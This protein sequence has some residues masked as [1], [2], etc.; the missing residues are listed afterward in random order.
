MNIDLIHLLNLYFPHKAS[1]G[2]FSQFEFKNS[3]STCTSN[4]AFKI[5]YMSFA[6]S[7][8]TFIEFSLPSYMSFQQ[9]WNSKLCIYWHKPQILHIHHP[10]IAWQVASYH[11]MNVSPTLLKFGHSSILKS[12]KWRAH[13][14]ILT[15]TIQAKLPC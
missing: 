5:S 11:W 8:V 1:F 2:I 4:K 9:I 7:Q 15:S 10:F 3:K 6:L 13:L 12:Y 14:L